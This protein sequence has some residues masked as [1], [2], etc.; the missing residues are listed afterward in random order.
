MQYIHFHLI[1]KILL[2]FNWHPDLID[3][4]QSYSQGH[5]VEVHEFEI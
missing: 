4:C 3:S 2:P 1:F 5:D